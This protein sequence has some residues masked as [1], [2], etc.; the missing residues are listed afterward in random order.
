MTRIPAISF[1]FIFSWKTGISEPLKLVY[2]SV[3]MTDRMPFHMKIRPGFHRPGNGFSTH[4]VIRFPGLFWQTESELRFLEFGVK[5]EAAQ[6]FSKSGPGKRSPYRAFFRS[7]K[8]SDRGYPA[9][10]NGPP[11]GGDVVLPGNFRCCQH[12]EKFSGL[13]IFFGFCHCDISIYP[14]PAIFPDDGILIFRTCGQSGVA[15]RRSR[16]R[17]HAYPVMGVAEKRKKAEAGDPAG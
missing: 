8:L 2:G 10:I 3:W 5:T 7:E 13:H 4:W 17:I 1:D 11:D 6:G 9:F 16:S 15:A 14:H 12:P